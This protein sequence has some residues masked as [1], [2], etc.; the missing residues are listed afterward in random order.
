MNAGFVLESEAISYL[1]KYNIP[2]PEHGLASSVYDA[3]KIA[4]SI[5]YPVVLKVVSRQV[6]HKSDVGGVAL[7]ISTPE[8]LRKAFEEIIARVSKVVSEAAIDGVLVCHQED[9]GIEVIVGGREDPVFGPLIMF[10]M[11]GVYTEI[12]NDVSFR[13]LPLERIDAE[14]LVREIQGFKVLNGFRGKPPCDLDRLI[15]LV[16]A[17]ARLITENSW[18]HE[19]DLNPVRIFEK[20]LKVLDVRIIGRPDTNGSQ[21]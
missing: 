19:L 14:E 20:G 21:I 12:L 9:E 5:G 11:G 8:K 17:T 4:D 15:D 13:I 3:L 1:E 2:Y 16:M 7:D 6:P 10:G 18:I